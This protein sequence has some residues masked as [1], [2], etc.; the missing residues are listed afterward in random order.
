MT[1]CVSGGIASSGWASS[2]IRSS[3]V[4]ERRRRPRTGPARPARRGRAGAGCAASDRV[5]E[6]RSN[7]WPGRGE[8]PTAVLRMARRSRARRAARRRPPRTRPGRR[9]PSARAS[10]AGALGLGGSGGERV[11]ASALRAAR[12]GR[13]PSA[14][15]VADLA[16]PLAG[17]LVVVEHRRVEVELDQLAD[18]PQRRLGVGDQVLVA[19]LEVAAAQPPRLLA[20]ALDPPPP[21]LGGRRRSACRRPSR[22]RAARAR[23]RAR[24]GSGG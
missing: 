16:Q 20:G 19:Q 5:V 8:E 4:P 15:Q 22:A 12:A 13:S 23:R 9:R 18:P 3:V 11:R 7:A 2:I 14:G 6:L 10:A 24:R 17:A 1:K 21:A